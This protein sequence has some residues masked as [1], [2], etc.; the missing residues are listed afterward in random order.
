MKT[1]RIK[2]SNTKTNKLNLDKRKYKFYLIGEKIC[3][4]CYNVTWTANQN[5]V[6]NAT[7]IH[8]NYSVKT[9]CLKNKWS[10]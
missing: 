6:T 2:D 1:F 10:K 7:Q 9:E 4:S 5:N 3:L 8:Y